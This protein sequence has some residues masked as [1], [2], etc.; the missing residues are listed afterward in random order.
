MQQNGCCI[1]DI[2]VCCIDLT[3]Y[4]HTEEAGQEKAVPRHA[5]WALK[6]IAKMNIAP[7][8]DCSQA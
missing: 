6:T 1:E 7:R 3:S 8:I 4:L 5:K 2:C